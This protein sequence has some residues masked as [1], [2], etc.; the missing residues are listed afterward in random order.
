MYGE[1]SGSEVDPSSEVSLN[2]PGRLLNARW[3]LPQLGRKIEQMR[4]GGMR[5][6]TVVQAGPDVAPIAGQH[7]LDGGRFEQPLEHAAR[8]PVLQALVRGERVFRPVPPMAELAH[9]QRVRL[10]VLVL[11][12]ALERVVAGEG[13]PTVRTL[14]GLVNAAARRRWHAQRHQLRR[15]SGRS[16]R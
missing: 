12:V 8:P 4:M 9:V 14:L 6:G 11:E 7:R 5:M 2:S 10:L 13:A 16:G 1:G 15:R 3:R